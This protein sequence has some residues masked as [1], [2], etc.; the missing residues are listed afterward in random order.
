ME[1]PRNVTH[2]RRWPPLAFY[3]EREY[4]MGQGR[5]RCLPTSLQGAC[6]SFEIQFA[7]LTMGLTRDAIYTF[8]KALADFLY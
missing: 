2:Q 6:V 7:F 8:S 4:H 3:G 1:E 5:K